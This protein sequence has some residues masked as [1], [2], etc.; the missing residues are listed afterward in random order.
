VAAIGRISDEDIALVRERVRID[1]VVR[2]YVALKPAGGGAY[3]GLCPFHDEKSPSFHVTPSRGMYYCFGCQ[4]GGD[5]ISFLRAMHPELTFAE[6]VER[7]ADGA[8]VTITR[9]AGGNNSSGLVKERAR[10]LEANRLAAEFFF[11]Q[12]SSGEAALGRKFLLDK[13][14][15]EIDAAKFGVGYAPKGWENLTRY[16][17]SQGVEHKDIV[18]VGLASEGTNGLYDKFRG[19]LIWPIRDISGSVLG[20][21]AR[22]IYED[23]EGPKYL[24]TSETALYK[25]SQVL[26]GLD[27]AK[28]SISKERTVVVVEGY[29]DVMACHLAGIGT[30]VAACGTAFGEGH[31]SILRRLIVDDNATVGKVIY[32]FDGDT[33]GQ[34]AALK[35]F[36]N[37]DKFTAQTYVAVAPA[38]MDPCEMRQREGDEALRSLVSNSTPLFEFA[39]KTALAKYDLDSAEDRVNGLREAAPIVG[40]IKDP[41]L[42][43]EYVRKLASWL[44]MDIDT[45]ARAVQ[46]AMRVV[47]KTRD[48]VGEKSTETDG[49]EEERK[50]IDP[51]EWEALKC[52]IQA[53]NFA[54]AWYSSIEPAC[55]SNIKLSRIH[56][57]LEKSGGPGAVV[58]AKP[59][60]DTV[61]ANCPGE[62]ERKLIQALAVEPIETNGEVTQEYVTSAIARLLEIAAQRKIKEIKSQIQRT[63]ASGGDATELL[64][65]AMALERY[66]RDLRDRVDGDE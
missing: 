11:R 10:L 24:N 26:Y 3:K 44:G 37:E 38:G 28:R 7:L 66:V 35:A 13:G 46:Q 53:P 33:A 23:D 61:L 20:F 48:K 58:G 6:A 39:I 56:E 18:N 5:A 60:I 49:P 41:S 57:T 19:R 52:A 65:T 29:T 8:G 34:K 4:E 15:S 59:W 36:D 1:D 21:G 55:F 64:E 25:K 30:A 16:L 47:I 9:V 22:K 50:S 12:F 42:K 62:D 32:T 27:M 17:L 45:V 14:F 40:R 31:I 63:I 51:I 2:E 43:P 54:S